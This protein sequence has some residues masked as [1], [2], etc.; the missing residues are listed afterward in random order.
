MEDEGLTL[1]VQLGEHVVQQED[2]PLPGL[3]LKNLPL[4]QLQ[5]QGRRP[6]LALGGVG[7]GVFPADGD[8]QVVLVGPGQALPLLD[9]VLS[10]LDP[11]RQA[12]V[13]RSRRRLTKWAR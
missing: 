12:F 8:S 2:G 10:E 7:L 13:A 4:G 6:G 3:L 5:G 11:R 1:G 9:D